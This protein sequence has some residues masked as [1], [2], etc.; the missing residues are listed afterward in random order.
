MSRHYDYHK[1]RASNRRKTVLR[2]E[3][4]R[5]LL[6]LCLGLPVAAVFIYLA[7]SK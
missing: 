5:L 1:P 4:L 2:R 7:L 3:R 6:M